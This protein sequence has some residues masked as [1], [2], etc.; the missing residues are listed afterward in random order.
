L[1]TVAS[2]TGIG[3][4]LEG[5]GILV[6]QLILPFAINDQKLTITD[7][8]LR[9]SQLGLTVKGA[10]D[11][12]EDTLDL[13]GTIIPVYTLNRLIGQVPIIGQILTGSEGRGA[14]AA[15]YQIK[16]PRSRPKV[17]VNP[18]SILTP[19]LVRDLFNGVSGLKVDDPN[20][21]ETEN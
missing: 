16:G 3:N 9:G 11:L 19:G 6:D 14:F 2:L 17:Y 8:L 13:A 7:G 5:E 20:G 10:I 15:T 1:L 21:R 4:L 12:E 18:L